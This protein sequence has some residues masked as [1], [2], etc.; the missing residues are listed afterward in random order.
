[1]KQ[2]SRLVGGILLVAGTTIGAGMLALPVSTGM[3]GFLPSIILMT[4]YWLYMTFTAFLML[5]V[6]LWMGRDNHL[7]TMAKSTLGPA[8]QAASWL[9]YL[10]LLYALTTAYIAGGGPIIVDA[11]E[12]LTGIVLPVWAGAVPLL[13]VFGFFVYKGTHYVDHINRIL[14]MGLVVAY[15]LMVTFLTPHVDRQLLQHV[16]FS[17]LWMG[18]SVVATSFGFHI[19]I[20]SLVSYLHRDV[21]KLKKV[22]LIGSLIPLLVYISWE[23]LALGIIPLSGDHGI[24]EGYLNGSNGVHLMTAFLGHSAIALVTTVF[25][26]FAIV[27][28]FL[29]VSL[30]LSDFLADGLAIKKTRGGRLSL[31]VMTFL[32]PLCISLVDPRAFLTALEYAGAFGVVTLL[33]LLPALMA[34]SGRYVR[35]LAPASAFRTPG[36]KV[37]L[38]AAMVISIAVI[39]LEVVT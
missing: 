1:M 37:A 8:G 30:S 32:P 14:M 33:G 26:F 25:S 23:F 35:H 13:V 2:H 34:W 4:C 27:T 21:A 18:V 6:N 3:S 39:V 29:G 10:F 19:I 31:Y 7:I 22:I 16:D 28:S 20:P 38:L 36:G 17:Y 15:F 12:F 24:M 11:F 9:I 5:E